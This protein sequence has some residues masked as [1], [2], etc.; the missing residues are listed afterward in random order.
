MKCKC[1][2]EMVFVTCDDRNQQT[3]PDFNYNLY[4]C[5]CGFILLDDIHND[6]R[7]W[8]NAVDTE[9]TVESK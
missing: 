6:K 3:E 4:N 9:L 1:G 2:E 8:I 5:G 7:L